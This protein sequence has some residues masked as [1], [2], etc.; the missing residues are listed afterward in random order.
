MK[1]STFSWYC[2]ENVPVIKHP[3]WWQV[4]R[5]AAM[6]YKEQTVRHM[7][8][9]IPEDEAQVILNNGPLDRNTTP[10]GRVIL[11]LMG[12]EVGMVQLEEHRQD[13]SGEGI[14][15]VEY[16]RTNLMCFSEARQ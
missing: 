6:G 14:K 11:R 1:T 13:Y 3:A 2:K 15:G 9:D 8:A 16:V 5:K 4:W 12:R 10:T 7:I